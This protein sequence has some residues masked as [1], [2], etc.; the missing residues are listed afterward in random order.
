VR[1]Q[2]CWYGFNQG[3]GPLDIPSLD[4]ESIEKMKKSKQCVTG[5]SVADVKAEILSFAV[6]EQ[7]QSVTGLKSMQEQLVSIEEQ[8]EG[9]SHN[10]LVRIGRL[11]DRL[12]IWKKAK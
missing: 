8:A 12:F 1:Y 11:M 6:Q 3:T 4:A 10:L 2:N 9:V 5:E 7:L